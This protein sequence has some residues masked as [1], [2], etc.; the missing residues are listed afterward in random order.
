MSKLLFNYF[1]NSSLS[2]FNKIHCDLW[3]PTL[4]SSFRNFLYCAC[5]VDDFT[6]YTWI[7]PLR[8]NSNVLLCSLHLRNIWIVNLTKKKFKY[9]I[10]MELVNFLILKLCLNFKHRA[11]CIKFLVHTLEQNGMVEQRHRIIRELGMTMHFHSRAPLYLWIEAFVTTVY[12]INCN[13]P[14]LILRHLILNYMTLIQFIPPY[15]YL[16]T[17]FSSTWD[18]KK[19]RQCLVFLLATETDIKDTSVLI[20]PPI[21]CLSLNM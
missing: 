12:L 16:V 9:F 17:L 11:S 10:L 13:L 8:K 15:I 6:W 4:V 1:K 2:A 20:L 7:V 19:N 18:T 21:K 5:F 3:G 14:L